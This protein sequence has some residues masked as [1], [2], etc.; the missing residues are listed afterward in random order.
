MYYK[1]ALISSGKTFF[2]RFV[3]EDACLSMIVIDYLNLS[4]SD[5][6]DRCSEFVCVNNKANTLGKWRL[7]FLAPLSKIGAFFFPCFTLKKGKKIL[8]EWKL[9]WITSRDIL[10]YNNIKS[11][12]ILIEINLNVYFS[13]LLLKYSQT[14]YVSLK[15]IHKTQIYVKHAKLIFN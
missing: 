3:Q 1:L 8:D 4:A 11:Y 6:S 7:S 14:D 9:C 5:W 2:L 10:N 13:D 12:E 15:S